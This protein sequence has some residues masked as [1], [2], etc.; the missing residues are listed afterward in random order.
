MFEYIRRADFP[1]WL[2]QNSLSQDYDRY[3]D[4]FDIRW[5]KKMSVKLMTIPERGMSFRSC[6]DGGSRDVWDAFDRFGSRIYIPVTTNPFNATEDN[7]V[8][9]SGDVLVRT[10]TTMGKPATPQVTIFKEA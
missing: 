1:Q 8:P 7:W 2:H 9:S 4:R 3:L 6:W 5:N 10:G